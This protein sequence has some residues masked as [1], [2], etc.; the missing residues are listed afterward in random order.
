VAVAG[1]IVS[2]TRNRLAITTSTPPPAVRSQSVMS[3]VTSRMPSPQSRS[4]APTGQGQRLAKVTSVA[5]V[6]QQS[7]HGDHPGRPAVPGRLRWLV[8]DNQ[9]PGHAATVRRITGTP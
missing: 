3:R 8:V 4:A 2:A 6:A 1:S 5:V 9:Q 7:Q